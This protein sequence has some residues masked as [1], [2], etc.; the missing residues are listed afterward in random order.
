MGGC[1]S[2]DG[3]ELIPVSKVKTRQWGSMRSSAG[4]WTCTGSPVKRSLPS[5]IQGPIIQSA[6]YPSHML[7]PPLPSGWLPASLFINRENTQNT[8]VHF[9]QPIS[10]TCLKPCLLS[11]SVHIL[12]KSGL[13]AGTDASQ[14]TL[15]SF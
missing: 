5:V 10:I 4:Q 8:S 9:C 7:S 2:D 12:I 1:G 13:L 11:D 14:D 6:D 3:K 15:V